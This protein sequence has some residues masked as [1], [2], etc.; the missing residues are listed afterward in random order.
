VS[1]RAP[2]EH[3]S[4][5]RFSLS[6]MTVCPQTQTLC[7]RSSFPYLELVFPPLREP[8]PCPPFNLYTNAHISFELRGRSSFSSK[9]SLFL[10]S[11]SRYPP[12]FFPAEITTSPSKENLITRLLSPPFLHFPPGSLPPPFPRGLP[13]SFQR[14]LIECAEV[15]K[16]TMRPFAPPV[17]GFF[18]AFPRT[19]N[20]W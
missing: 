16:V 7:A 20:F 3:G 17:E 2:Y 4:L 15:R 14:R 8:L 6:A 12:R 9:T 5:W 13:F 19:Q 11:I 10:S 18:F 1:H